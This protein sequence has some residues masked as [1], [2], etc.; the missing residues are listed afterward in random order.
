MEAVAPAD[1]AVVAS[2][3]TFLATACGGLLGLLRTNWAH[4][5]CGSESVE[6]RL[7][8]ASS[9]RV[10]RVVPGQPLMSLA[11]TA[12]AARDGDTIEVES[13]D[14]AGDV[15]SWPQSDL[16]IRGIGPRPRL[17]A[18]GKDAEGKGIL[19]LKGKRV[20]IENLEFREAR[21]RDRNGAGIRVEDG[22]LT[23]SGCAFLDNENGI[24]AGNQR[25]VEIAIEHSV[26][27][28]NGHTNG[29]AHN[30]YVGTIARLDVAGCLFSRSRVGHLLK[31]RAEVNN[32]HYCRLTC[33][34]GTSSYELEFPSGGRAV[35]VG[36]LIQ[37]GPASENSTVVSYGAE[38][39]RWPDNSLVVAFNTL[40]NDRSAGGTFVRVAKGAQQVTLLNNLFVGPGNLNID[41]P[42]NSR[43]NIEAAKKEFSDP[44]KFDY[45]LRPKSSLVGRAGFRGTGGEV[46]S[47]VR[48]Y[49]HPASSCPLEGLTPLTPLSPGAFQRVAR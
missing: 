31:S 16:T 24:L 47:P 25:T 30:L 44:A 15:S 40:V 20:R 23:V 12:R 27:D 28:G 7:L 48:E 17:I 35:V 9:G 19:V 6:S 39:Y 3:R 22:P 26:F 38:G 42:L 13:G 21:V 37:Q 10:L 43:G 14:Y 1:G 33:E 36:N 34:D 49:V 45:R 46:E 32:V 18:D 2:R 29:S 41:A 4:A 11:A 5:T 8:P